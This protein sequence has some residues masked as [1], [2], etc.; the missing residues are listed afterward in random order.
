MIYGDRVKQV[1]EL[2]GWTQTE[3]AGALGVTQPYVAQVESGKINASIEFLGKLS[4]I[5][6][7]ALG[8]FTRQPD[9]DFPAGS[10]LFR[11]HAKITSTARTEV[12]RYTQVAYGL[13]RSVHDKARLKQLAIRL[14]SGIGDDPLLAARITRSELGLSPDV[15]VPNLINLLERAGV[16]VIASQ[17]PFE[18][19]DAFSVWAGVVQQQPIVFFSGGKAGDRLRF[20]VAHELGHLV[21]HKPLAGELDKIEE[22][23]YSFAAEFLLPEVAMREEILPPVTLETFLQLKPRWGVSI[24]AMIVRAKNLGIITPRKYKYLFQQLSSRGWRT[25]EPK[26]VLVPAEKPRA[27]RQIVESLYGSPIDYERFSTDVQINETFLR[28]I[29]EAYAERQVESVIGPAAGRNLGGFGPPK[30]KRVQ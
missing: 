17:K 26:E 11:A 27:L 7:F 15:P 18:D 23:A 30:S 14:P 21:M 6:G 3:L 1:R 5:T 10:L 29:I 8:F 28:C 25:H 16:V 20:S 12:Y 2:N 24:Q 4:F 13:F 19:C 9:Y 22:Q